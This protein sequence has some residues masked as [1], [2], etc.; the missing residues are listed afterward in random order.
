VI[1]L[2]WLL[3]LC[4]IMSS[5]SV[6]SL[7]SDDKIIQICDDISEWPPFIFLRRNDGRITQEIK[8]FSVQVIESILRKNNLKYELTLLPWKRCLQ[9]VEKGQS[10]SMLLNS[11][12]NEERNQKY[13]Y[14]LPYY[15][16]RPHYFYSSEHHPNGL[17]IQ[18]KGD[19]KNYRVGGLLGYSYS[20]WGLSRDEVY[21]KGIY[22][23]D[24]LLTHLK[25]NDIDLFVENLEIIIGFNMIGK[26]YI[27]D[28]SLRFKPVMDMP[29]T[30]FYMLFTRNPEGKVLQKM[31]NKEIQA[32]QQEG[33]LEQI[34]APYLRSLP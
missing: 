19:L 26:S 21:S 31:V 11:S 8:G 12:F 22:N 30:P 17:S 23:F 16:I 32:M 7:A 25:R 18:D 3:L 15:H 27:E 6:S 2:C 10:Y 4:V 28:P 29:P 14:S 20:Y 5:A 33:E 1:K 24:G 13:Y 9:S 34:L